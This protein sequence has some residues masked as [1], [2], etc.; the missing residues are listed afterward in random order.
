MV[1]GSSVMAV[2]NLT[3]LMNQNSGQTQ[4]FRLNQDFDEISP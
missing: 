2:E 4:P 3:G 1:T